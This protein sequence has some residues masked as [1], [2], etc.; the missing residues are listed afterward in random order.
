MIDSHCHLD[1]A[2]F[3]RD[4][5]EVLDRAA[6]RRRDR[7]SWSRRSGR[8][9]GPRV[10]ALRAAPGDRGSRSAST[11]RSCPSS[12]PASARSTPETLARAIVEA[13]AVAVGECGLDG[14]TA[15]RALQ[16]TLFR[17]QVRAARRAAAAR[18]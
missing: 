10:L 12:T 2:A 7:R 13:G 17:V 11:R 14:G 5:D 8:A 9:R 16:E 3:D 4:R 6:R 1:L 18:S 15:E